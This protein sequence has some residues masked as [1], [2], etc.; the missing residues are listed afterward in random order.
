MIARSQTSG[1]SE[2]VTDLIRRLWSEDGELYTPS[3][4]LRL[5]GNAIN[6][7]LPSFLLINFDYGN[8]HPNHNSTRGRT[9]SNE[10]TGSGQQ[11]GYVDTNLK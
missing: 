10:K 11:L 7:S 4:K 8:I 3:K 2:K 9:V 1:K 6:I 5:L